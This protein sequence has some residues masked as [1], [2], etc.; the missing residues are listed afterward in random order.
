MRVSYTSW[1]TTPN[2][3]KMDIKDFGEPE[4][5]GATWEEYEQQDHFVDEELGMEEDDF[6]GPTYGETEYRKRLYQTL[7]EQLLKVVYNPPP[8]YP[9]RLEYNQ[10]LDIDLKIVSD[11]NRWME[12]IETYPLLRTDNFLID[13]WDRLVAEDMKRF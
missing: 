1:F 9:T 13:Q 10:W 11:V 5:F 4:D 3:R 2:G 7:F 6:E 12:V 8:I